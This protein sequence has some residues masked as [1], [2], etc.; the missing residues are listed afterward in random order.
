[1]L[2]EVLPRDLIL[3]V[4]W[5]DRSHESLIDELSRLD[6]ATEQEVARCYMALVAAVTRDFHAE[7]SMM[8]HLDLPSFHAHREQHAMVLANLYQA[9]PLFRQGNVV[10]ARKVIRLLLQWLIIHVCTMDK[11]LAE[12]LLI[13]QGRSGFEQDTTGYQPVS[14]NPAGNGRR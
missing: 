11:A 5:M 9:V 12:A 6:R 4:P 10:A 1:M 2:Q 14:R 13:A 3:G 7:E 8:A